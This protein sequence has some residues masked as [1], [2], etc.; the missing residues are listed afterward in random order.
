MEQ[1]A[2]AAG[3]TKSSLY[4][5]V[6]SKEEFLARALD[7][8]FSALFAV[9]DEPGATEGRAADRLRYIL[10]RAVETEIQFLPEVSLLLRVRG[11]TQTERGALER[12]REFDAFITTLV[13]QAVK[14][15]EVRADIDPALLSRLLFGMAHWLT[16]WYRPEGPL[17]AAEI[18]DAILKLAFEGIRRPP[19]QPPG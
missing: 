9:L 2:H 13:R 10:R 8:A 16:D 19:D 5:H 17:G 12:R 18:V 15:G 7:R 1:I 14:A 4:H 3:I 11:N 6:T